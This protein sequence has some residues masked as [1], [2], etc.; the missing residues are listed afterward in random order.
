[1]L[2]CE[3]CFLSLT[4]LG[5]TPDQVQTNVFI[6]GKDASQ[7]RPRHTTPSP[8]HSMQQSGEPRKGVY[9]GLNQE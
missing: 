8:R 3:C 4:P 2:I 1:M 7:V 5:N 6:S 9:S